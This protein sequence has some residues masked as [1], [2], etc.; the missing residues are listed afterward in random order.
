M[1]G[2]FDY[3]TVMRRVVKEMTAS[4]LRTVDYASGYSCRTLVAVR[5]AI[6]TGVSQLSAQINEKIAK[7]LG[8]DTFE[9]TWHAGHRP[10][11][12]WGGNVYTKQELIS[13]CGLG[14]VS[15]LC[16]A[17]CRHSYMAFVKGY[18]VRTYTPE[19]LREL[20]RKEQQ[21]R[22]Y[23]GK[24]YTPYQASQVQRQMETKMR[25][26]RAYVKGLQQGGGST[27]DV[28]AA[29]SRY[30]NTLHQ[31]QNFSKKMKLP[32]Q[33]E[34]V[35]MDGLGRIAPS[36]LR[37]QRKYQKSLQSQL[38]YVYNGEKQFIPAKS[39]FKNTK[40]IAG[41]GSKT[42]L[43]VAEKLAKKYGGTASEW[44]KYVG[45]IESDKYI[46]DVHWY[47][48]KSGNQY[49]AKLKARKEK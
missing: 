19:Q 8:T 18:S 41:N 36:K 32:E 27:D 26:Q 9:V 42:E 33:M 6:M 3:N 49:E 45:K 43:R 12:W 28:I 35:Y 14:D 16:G 20:E 13:V 37:V 11:H 2:A 38:A 17:N 4:G 34:R 21:T 10:S 5:R 22:P 7:D 40:I 24:E 46:F 15:G 44:S 31:Y 48:N 39:I 47:E 25:N 1:T 30:L 29:K 23:N